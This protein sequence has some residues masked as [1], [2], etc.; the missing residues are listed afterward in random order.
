[1]IVNKMAQQDIQS[2]NCKVF[3]TPLQF[4]INFTK[5]FAQFKV[6]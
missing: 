3:F 2:T 4:S 1:M 6:K 5:K